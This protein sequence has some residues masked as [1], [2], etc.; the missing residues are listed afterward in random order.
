M[1]IKG[2][3]HQRSGS[4]RA[5]V[6]KGQ[7][8]QRPNVIKGQGR[9]YIFDKD[10]RYVAGALHPVSVVAGVH[11]AHHNVAVVTAAA[12]AAAARAVRAGGSVRG[13]GVG[14]GRI[15]VH[16]V[17]G[18]AT[19]HE[20]AG[21]RVVLVLAA[22]TAAVHIDAQRV[23]DASCKKTNIKHNQTWLKNESITNDVAQVGACGTSQTP[24][25]GANRYVRL[26]SPSCIANQSIGEK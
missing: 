10:F 26:M 7:G 22:A 20:S 5:K 13:H 19:V 2:Q 18:S 25:V 24:T 9:T 12:T 17:H 15:A 1:V 8:H 16:A 4:P 21:G 23:E 11:V 3:G 6:I 14:A